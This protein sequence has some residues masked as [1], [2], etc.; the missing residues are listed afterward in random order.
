MKSW[1]YKLAIVS[2]VL[3]SQCK[4]LSNDRVSTTKVAY[5]DSIV[6]DSNVLAVSLYN[7]IDTI[8]LL[9][10]IIKERYP[11][12]SYLGHRVGDLDDDKIDDIILVIERLC[13]ESDVEFMSGVYENNRCRNVIFL[14]KINKDKNK[15]VVIGE[16]NSIVGCSECGGGGVGDPTLGSGGSFVFDNGTITYSE[17]YGACCKTSYYQKYRYD[18]IKRKWVLFQITD[19]THCCNNDFDEDGKAILTTAIKTQKDFGDTLFLFR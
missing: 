16:N 2:F 9:K 7:K 4:P 11:A 12:Y 15:Y 5:C 14:K 19:T 13:N 1:L 17:M 8:S 10:E 3:L 6:N 18:Y